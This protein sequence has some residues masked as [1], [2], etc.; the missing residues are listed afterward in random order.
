[1][2]R[3]LLVAEL[4][5]LFRAHREVMMRRGAECSVVLNMM[6]MRGLNTVSRGDRGNTT[7]EHWRVRGAVL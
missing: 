7:C 4:E 2:L 3:N 1:M 5:E 6:T